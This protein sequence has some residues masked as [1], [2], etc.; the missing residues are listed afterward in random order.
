MTK[1]EFVGER[2]LEWQHRIEQEKIDN[3]ETW[4]DAGRSFKSVRNRLA[5]SQKTIASMVGCAE[6][7]ISRFEHGKY[8]KKRKIITK[9]YEMALKLIDA[10]RT[11]ALSKLNS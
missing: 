6:S 11:I 8:I 9:G 4:L 7:V 10:Q 1:T 3:A 2:V 5:V